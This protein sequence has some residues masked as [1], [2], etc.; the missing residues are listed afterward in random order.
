MTPTATATIDPTLDSDGDGCGDGA[1]LAQGLDP[2]DPWDFYDVPSPALFAAPDPTIVM[3]DH[4]I[5]GSDAQA[6]F[7]YFKA[8][9]KFGTTVY[10]QDLDLDGHPDGEEYDRTQVGSGQSG[11]PDG[12]VAAS[13]AQ[14]AFAEFKLGYQC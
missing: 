13:D 2:F 3:R 5:G 12:I 14:L 10:D 1:E 6:V 4:A 8:G 9:A 11:P 7:A